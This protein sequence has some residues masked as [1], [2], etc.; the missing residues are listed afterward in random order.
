MKKILLLTFLFLSILCNAG[1][2]FNYIQ[3]Q[4]TIGGNLQEIANGFLRTSDGGY[5][6]G[7][8]SN[9]GVSGEKA[10]GNRGG[11][12]DYWIIKFNSN[13][14]IEWQKTIGGAKEDYFYSIISTSDGGYLIG[15]HSDSNISGEKTENS[16]GGF[17]YWILK[18]N[19]NGGIEWQKSYGGSREDNLTEILKTTD[20][21]Y[22]LAGS[23]KSSISFD[24]SENNKGDTTT[25]DFWVIK[26][27]STG[28]IQWQKTIGGNNQDILTK[29]ISTTDGYLLVGNSSSSVSG[30]FNE[31]NRGLLDYW[32]VKINLSGNIIWKKRFGGNQNDKLSCIEPVN[33]G[34]IIGGSSN[35]GATGDKSENNRGLLYT[36]DYWILNINETGGLLWQKTIGGSSDDNLTSIKATFGGGLVLA[37]ISGSPISGEKTDTVRGGFYNDIWVVRLSPNRTILWQKTIGSYF[38]DVVNYIDVQKEN[39]YL[40]VGGVLGNYNLKSGDQ[41]E[42]SRGGWDIWII[43]LKSLETPNTIKGNVFFARNSDCTFDS[44]EKPLSN[45]YIKTEPYNFYG[46]TDSL[47]RYNI[48]T[49]SGTY[50]VSQ[51]IPQ[52]IRMLYSGTKCPSQGFYNISMRRLDTT[53]SN[54]NFA[55]SLYL[56]P[57]LQVELSQS[58]LRRCFNNTTAIRY[59]N[60]GNVDTSNV[61][62]IVQ[63]P[64]YVTLVSASNPNY[65]VNGKKI[66]FTI[67]NLRANECGT[68]NLVTNV[69]CVEGIV[70]LT[71]CIRAYILPRNKCVDQIQPDYVF[72]DRSEITIYGICTNSTVRFVI[73]NVGQNM[74]D[75]SN[76][77]IYKN[78]VQALSA[79]F[80]LTAGDSLV[81][82]ISATGH[83]FRLEADQTLHYPRDYNPFVFFSHTHCVAISMLLCIASNQQYLPHNLHL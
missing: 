45:I 7:C 63:L 74:A 35:S 48:L 46:I 75:S 66:T 77:R 32:I 27:N 58:R 41:S 69:D 67:G 11:S 18:L 65:T 60:I 76:Y 22:L 23:S 68:I 50:K 55:D 78:A 43:N 31:V 8:T 59:C 38:Q 6:I 2:P 42:N 9:S 30:D 72:W 73:K 10:E 36:T 71:Q 21:E 44:N 61:Q 34:Y 20:G 15:G 47:G 14:N 37:G 28:S 53:V 5:I 54:I 24:K 17:D 26:I 70:G 13:N 82:N 80:K 56:C 33:N 3:W 57:Y 25:F 64:E 40:L 52:S 39:E 81:I 62:V 12:G 1:Q 16:K 29:A 83:T 4:K 79:K 51:I 49:D 19:S